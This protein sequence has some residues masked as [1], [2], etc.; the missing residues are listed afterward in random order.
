MLGEA[1]TSVA[2]LRPAALT[3]PPC[4][5]GSTAHPLSQAQARKAYA[6]RLNEATA[7]EP[8]A[9]VIV[10]GRTAA[11]DAASAKESMA[12]AAEGVVSSGQDFSQLKEG[13]HVAGLALAYDLDGVARY[14]GLQDEMA[15]LNEE[16]GVMSKKASA[17][18][19]AAAHDATLDDSTPVVERDV[20]VSSPKV[21]RA[22]VYDNDLQDTLREVASSDPRYQHAAARRAA[23]Y[24]VVDD[25]L[26]QM[27]PETVV[28]SR[29]KPFD[30]APML[31]NWADS[32]SS[33]GTR[34][35]VSY[36]VFCYHG[37]DMME[38]ENTKLL[39][40]F[41]SDNGTILP[42][43]LTACCPKHQRRLAKVLKRARVL[44]VMPW[45]G[46]LHPKLRFMQLEA[47][48]AIEGT[49]DERELHRL[50]ART[51]SAEDSAVRDNMAALEA[52][53]AETDSAAAAA[54]RG[55]DR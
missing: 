36:C 26:L 13:V 23:E 17:E 14:A 43:R 11:A 24:V 48:P 50:T 20:D 42:R 30:P 15:A 41:V 5:P 31:A 37:V 1:A 47:D 22:M 40:N 6:E 27:Q 12:D 19:L 25:H 7:I 16:Y 45:Q 52:L 55:D 3:H 32:Q 44:N 18:E 49:T 53:L 9:P 34:L 29:A 8:E 4:P 33:L 54:S 21:P 35:P 46:R 51:A 10:H 2:I 38:P 39:S 28:P